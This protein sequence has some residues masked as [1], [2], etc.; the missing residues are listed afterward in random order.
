MPQGL[1]NVRTN[2]W[3]WGKFSSFGMEVLAKHMGILQGFDENST[4]SK[5]SRLREFTMK[6]PWEMTTLT[7]EMV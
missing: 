6:N 7:S 4:S 1:R 3:L 2:R 5:P